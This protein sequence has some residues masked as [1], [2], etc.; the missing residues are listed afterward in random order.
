VMSLRAT[1]GSVAISTFCLNKI[2]AVASLLAT[3]STLL[4]RNRGG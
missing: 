4:Q 1:E 2:T 3:T